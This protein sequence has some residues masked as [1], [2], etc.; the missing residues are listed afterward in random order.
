[1]SKIKIAGL[2]QHGKV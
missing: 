1:M 2:D